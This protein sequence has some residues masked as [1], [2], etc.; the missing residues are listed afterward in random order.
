MITVDELL[1]RSG[2]KNIR[3]EVTQENKELLNDFMHFNG[4]KHYKGYT[5]RW[6]V[7]TSIGS[8]LC[9]PQN[10]P[11]FW[12]L[13]SESKDKYLKIS[14]DTFKKLLNMQDTPVYDIY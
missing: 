9:I 12:S 11:Y 3:I 4:S 5:H 1:S 6:S 14:T 7:L 10:E 2:L 8:N 13:S